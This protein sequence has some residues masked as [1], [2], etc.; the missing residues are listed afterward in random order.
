VLFGSAGFKQHTE[1]LE[2]VVGRFVIA[3]CFLHAFEER[4]LPAG[5][6]VHF[7][8][9]DAADRVVVDALRVL[10]VALAARLPVAFEDVAGVVREGSEL[11]LSWTHAGQSDDRRGGNRTDTSDDP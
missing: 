1:G 4:E 8:L 7:E 6:E 11:C 3:V 9:A 5:T 2:E 10:S